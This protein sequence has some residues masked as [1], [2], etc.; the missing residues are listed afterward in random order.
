[1][2]SQEIRDTLKP[3]INFA[4]AIV[5]CAEIVD[6]AEQAEKQLADMDKVLAEKKQ[7]N[8]NVEARGKQLVEQ[9]AALQKTYTDTRDDL[10]KKIGAVEANLKTARDNAETMKAQID[11]DVQDKRDVLTG[12]NAEIAD[13]R[14]RLEQAKKSLADW[15]AANSLKVA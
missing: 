12:L 6:A 11:K 13:A 2:N 9:T 8:A 5:R 1:M 14:K 4:P 15:A 3:M 10:D 7:E